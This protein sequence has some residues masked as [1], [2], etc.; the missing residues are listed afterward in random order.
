[1][2]LHFNN[3]M[4]NIWYDKFMFWFDL[5]YNQ[6]MIISDEIVCQPIQ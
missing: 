6:N 5:S 2:M 3:N 4:V 1:M